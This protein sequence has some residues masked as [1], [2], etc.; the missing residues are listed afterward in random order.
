[1]S[2]EVEAVFLIS[3]KGRKVFAEFKVLSLSVPDL[4]V[5]DSFVR[6]VCQLSREELAN[7]NTTQ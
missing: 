2:M 5:F 6:A 7:L 3:D 1:M 4:P